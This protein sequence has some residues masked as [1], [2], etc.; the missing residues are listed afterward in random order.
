MNFVTWNIEGTRDPRM[1][2]AST[3]ENNSGKG[4]R[5]RHS[6]WSSSCHAKWPP[7]KIS[8]SRS[9]RH[10]L[11][12]V[13]STTVM[14]NE[15]QHMNFLSRIFDK[16]KLAG[17]VLAD[18]MP[19]F[20]RYFLARLAPVHAKTK[21]KFNSISGSILRFYTCFVKQKITQTH[22]NLL[23]LFFQHLF[24]FQGRSSMSEVYS[25]SYARFEYC[26]FL[27]SV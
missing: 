4:E 9:R 24:K 2:L 11:T 23:C 18:Q 3:L 13:A 12:I 22:F 14:V 20:G 1:F 26:E 19:H 21:L 10:F 6:I 16:T 5:W 25:K 27:N 7:V 17:L 15:S 8:F